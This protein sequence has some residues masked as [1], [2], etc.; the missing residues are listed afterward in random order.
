MYGYIY[1]TAD[2][3]P[4][5]PSGYSLKSK[6]G[7][8]YGLSWEPEATPLLELLSITVTPSSVLAGTGILDPVFTLA[9][10]GTPSGVNITSAGTGYKELSSPFEEFTWT[11][12]FPTGNHNTLRVF[13]IAATGMAANTVSGSIVINFLPKA[14]YAEAATGVVFNESF[15]KNLGNSFLAS[16]HYGT[17]GADAGVGETLFYAVVNDYGTPSVIHNGSNLRFALTLATGTAINVTN[18][19]G[20]TTEYS[21]YRTE[22]DSTGEQFYELDGTA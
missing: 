11:G 3:R 4:I 20:Y 1:K 2:I 18:E 14:Y 17:I 16:G 5:G 8:R 22:Y 6:P 7:A 10:R 19:A 13:N 15:I 9:W 21:L 12:V